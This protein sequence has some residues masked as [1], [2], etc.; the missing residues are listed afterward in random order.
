MFVALESYTTLLLRFSLDIFFPFHRLPKSRVRSETSIMSEIA[1]NAFLQELEQIKH[2]GGTGN[3]SSISIAF[4]KLL[5]TYARQKDIDQYKEQ[6]P[7]HP[8]IA[9]LFNT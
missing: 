6:K 7:K 5:S 3:E 2:R 4:H 1:I 9:R 8:T